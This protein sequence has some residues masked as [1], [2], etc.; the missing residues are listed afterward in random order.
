MVE[1]YGS[2]GKTDKEG[3]DPYADSVGAGIYGGVVKRDKA[4]KIVIGRQYQNHNP[5]PGPVYAGG[6]YTP[7]TKA[8]KSPEGTLTSSSVLHFFCCK[9][10]ATCVPAVLTSEDFE[11]GLNLGLDLG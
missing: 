10:K 8:L 4:G 1:K 2:P 6:G 3:F 11:L 9:K 5:R 7:S